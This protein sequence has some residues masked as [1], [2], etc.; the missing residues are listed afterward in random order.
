MD[1]ILEESIRNRDINSLENALLEEGKQ[2]VEGSTLQSS[3][4]AAAMD[5]P[6]AEEP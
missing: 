2:R 6:E 5:A 1:A 3:Q 4:E